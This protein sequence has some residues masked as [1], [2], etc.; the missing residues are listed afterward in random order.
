MAVIAI[1]AFEVGL[2][3]FLY[4]EACQFNRGATAP[5]AEAAVQLAFLNLLT[6]GPVW[7]F[8]RALESD[9]A[10]TAGEGARGR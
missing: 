6:G 2:G 8:M 10:P 3:S 4:R 7:L 1:T 9:P 5:W